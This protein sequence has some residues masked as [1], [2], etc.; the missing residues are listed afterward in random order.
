MN[1]IDE[2]TRLRQDTPP[3]SAHARAR[4]RLR[5]QA[6][7]EGSAAAPRRRP[8]ARRVALL[9]AAVVALT[10]ALVGYQ[11]VGPPEAG[12]TAEAATVLQRAAA[13]AGATAARA[14]QPDQFTYVDVVHVT[15]GE[16][17][18]VQTW[19]SVD[20]SRPGL[21]RSAGFLGARSEEIPPYDAAAGLSTAPYAV[22]AKLPTEPAAL[23][24]VLQADP[25]VKNDVRSNGVSRDVGVW[26]LIRE[27]VETAPAPQRAALF[28]TASRI[29]GITYVATATDAAGRAGEAVGLGDPRLGS[30]QFIFDKRTHEFLGERILNR[31]STT[32][33]QFN[34][35]V[36]QTGIVDKVGD[37]PP[38]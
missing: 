11:I 8:V 15:G 18:R 10:A 35:A 5:L 12:S 14:P 31:G 30:V 17:Q 1:E 19:T 4:G 21:I 24:N 26:S 37:T 28:Q 6:E 27:L 29:E 32:Q 2:L 20:G 7:I 3:M 34:D 33:V 9:G 25:Y 38:K 23:L 16:R 22:L 13:V 36:Q